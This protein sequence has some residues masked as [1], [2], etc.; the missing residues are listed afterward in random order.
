[1][2][3]ISLSH[4]SSIPKLIHEKEGDLNLLIH[5]SKPIWMVVNDLGQRVVKLGEE[6]LT[7]SEISSSI[8]HVRCGKEEG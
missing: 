8:E 4:R 7:L 5:P 2:V 1:M 3:E 6:G